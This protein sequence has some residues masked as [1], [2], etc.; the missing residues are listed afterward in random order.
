MDKKF[1]LLHRLT[2]QRGNIDSM[3]R[4][5]SE[6]QARYCE[7]VEQA[8]NAKAK[9]RKMRKQFKSLEESMGGPTLV[10]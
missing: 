1:Q 4:L 7:L 6:R 8:S 2:L 10:P 3:T 9:L 5:I